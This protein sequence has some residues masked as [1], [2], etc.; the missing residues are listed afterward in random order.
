MIILFPAIRLLVKKKKNIN[1]L[2]SSQQ[3]PYPGIL[4]IKKAFPSASMLRLFHGLKPVK[5]FHLI[6]REFSYGNLFYLLYL[7]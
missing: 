7:Q 5:L 4:C 1:S 3:A 6:S 2:T